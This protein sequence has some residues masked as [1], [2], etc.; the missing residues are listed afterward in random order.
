MGDGEKR[1]LKKQTLSSELHLRWQGA[2]IKGASK[3][4]SKATSGLRKQQN[5]LIKHSLIFD[6]IKTV[7]NTPHVTIFSKRK[8]G[9][10]QQNLT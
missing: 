5:I 10:I 4:D 7:A 8:S 1:T 6:G 9:L 2:K 3:V